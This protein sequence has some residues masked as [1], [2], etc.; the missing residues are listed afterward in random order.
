MGW[1]NELV[2]GPYNFMMLGI[3]KRWWHLRQARRRVHDLQK[4]TINI[5]L[6]LTKWAGLE[7]PNKIMFIWCDSEE[8]VHYLRL[9]KIHDSLTIEINQVWILS[10]F[11]G[12]CQDKSL[13]YKTFPITPRTDHTL[14]WYSKIVGIFWLNTF[15]VGTYPMTGRYWSGV[16]R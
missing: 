10:W 1:G 12:S 16:T 7:G 11:G 13:G 8:E 14:R 9:I 3:I 4:F 5:R 15:W 2:W 6:R